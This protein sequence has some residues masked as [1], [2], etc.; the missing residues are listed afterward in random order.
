M[1]WV[2]LWYLCDWLGV[3]RIGSVDLWDVIGWELNGLGRSVEC[4]WSGVEQNDRVDLL[5]MMG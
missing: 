2:D 5:N 3:D 1:D 4:D